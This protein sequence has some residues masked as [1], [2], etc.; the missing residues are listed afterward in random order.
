[1]DMFQK[2]GFKFY[3]DIGSN[4]IFIEDNKLDNCIEYIIKKDIRSIFV[5]D[6]Y[7]RKQNIEMT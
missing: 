1:M 6:D 2:D 7:Y 4:F 5:N 3:E